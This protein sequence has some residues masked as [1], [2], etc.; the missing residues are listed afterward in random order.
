MSIRGLECDLKDKEHAELLENN[1][2]VSTLESRG[3][4]SLKSCVWKETVY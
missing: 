4:M 2:A 3:V 1:S